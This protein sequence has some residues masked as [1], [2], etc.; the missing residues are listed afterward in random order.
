M[1]LEDTKQC[2]SGIT[3]PDGYYLGAVNNCTLC[4]PEC[5]KCTSATVCT[6]CIL[7]HKLKGTNCENNCGNGIREDIEYCDDG[8]D[9]NGDGCRSDCTVEDNFVCEQ[10]VML[11]GGTSAPDICRCDPLLSI[12]EWTDFWGTIRL[13]FDSEIYFNASAAAK[14]DIPLTF[15]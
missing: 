14:S 9:Q 6:A 10:G 7:G 13:K 11:V 4:K 3:C 12:A 8:N 2:T 5:Q 1:L 15:C